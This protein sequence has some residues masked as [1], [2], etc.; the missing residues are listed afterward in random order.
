MEALTATAAGSSGVSE[1]YYDS[2]SFVIA[3][4]NCSSR[5]ITNSMM[6][7]VGTPER[8]NVRVK[9]IG[10]D[11]AATYRGT[12]RWII[13]DDSGATHTWL[14]PDTYYH[15]KSPYRLLSP[16]HWAQTRQDNDKRGTMCATYYDAVKLFWDDCKFVRTVPLDGSSN[17]AL[18]R[19]Q[20]AYLRFNS[21][22]MK[23]ADTGDA[24][25]LDERELLSL[26]AVQLVSDDEMTDDE[27]VADDMEN[28]L[29]PDLPDVLFDVQ[30][31][32]DEFRNNNSEAPSKPTYSVVPEDE[33][34]QYQSP[35]A[36]FLALHYK[37]AHLSPEKMKALARRGQ[38][39]SAILKCDMPKCSASLEP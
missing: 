12:V 32:T 6:D 36:R 33:D 13:Q 24:S 2:D 1:H 31:H 17:I 3:V 25:H 37:H 30:Q 7:F 5:C 35:Q 16:Q 9:G 18:I 20:P 8:I 39:P 27:S 10:G 11:G 26:P 28:R 21:F 23:I 34:V 29:H 22:C 14:I 38:L 19:S 4:D 15:K